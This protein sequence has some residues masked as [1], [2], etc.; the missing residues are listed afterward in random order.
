MGRD[1]YKLG[2]ITDIAQVGGY[3]DYKGEPRKDSDLDGMPDVYESAY[4]LN[5]NDA[6]DA[7]LDK[8]GDG[9]TNIEMYINGIDPDK[10][11]DWKNL[12]NNKDVLTEK[13][14]LK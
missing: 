1:S 4:G 8:D 10:K 11:I 5:P 12:S 2:I 7:V 14:G 6:S 3:P 13:G 9:Y